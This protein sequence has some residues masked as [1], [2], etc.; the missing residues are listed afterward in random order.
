MEVDDEFLK[1]VT[2]GVEAKI[3]QYEEYANT[4][5]EDKIDLRDNFRDLFGKE[6]DELRCLMIN[7]EHHVERYHNTVKELEKV[8][9]TN[10]VHQKATYWK[11]REQFEQDLTFV[12]RFLSQFHPEIDPSKEYKLNEFSETHDPNIYIQDGPLACYCSHLRAMIYAYLNFEDYTIII[13]DDISITNTDRIK[14]YL[15]QVPDDWDI[16]CLGA[17]AKFRQYNEADTFYKFD[18]DFHSTHFYIIRN[19]AFPKIFGGVYPITDQIDVLLSDMKD[20][21]NIYNI[22]YS[23][24]QKNIGT[25]TQNNLNVIFNSPNYAGLRS[26]LA[27]MR[28][29]CIHFCNLLLPGNEAR[30]E[31]IAD[32]LM[33]DVVFEYILKSGMDGTDSLHKEVY[34]ADYSRYADSIEYK[35]LLGSMFFFVRCCK[36]GIDPHMIAQSLVNNLLFTIEKFKLHSKSL[37]A[38]GFGSSAHVYLGDDTIVKQYNDKLRWTTDGYDNPLEIYDN[39]VAILT[40]V[41]GCKHVPVLIDARD[42]IIVMSYDGKSLYEEFELS[43]NWED[44]IR[45][46]FAEF[47]SVG[48]YYPEF[49]LQN[50]LVKDGKIVF[51]DYGMARVCDD[52]NADNCEKFIIRLNMLRDRL[53]SVTDAGKRHELIN[54]FYRNLTLN[55]QN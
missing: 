26:A 43:G 51:V 31:V 36:K 32:Y 49:R 30:N 55:G 12:M 7:L 53:A 37:K 23:V 5:I 33:Y 40:R 29:R 4:R 54:T 22:P 48:V 45:E 24:Y 44:Q 18:Q 42:D 35:E 39:E 6:F 1:T 17:V 19:R 21:L 38:Y 14:N 27:V 25:N 9:C 16:I 28:H 3:L 52:K 11:T 10:L 34:D 2:R 20:E 50:I 46:A 47:D 15:S 8:S 41:Q 13:E